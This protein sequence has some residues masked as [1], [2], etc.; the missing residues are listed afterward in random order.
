M[1]GFFSLF[2]S[3][4]ACDVDVFKSLRLSRS[5]R[6]KKTCVERLRWR[7]CR[8]ASAPLAVLDVSLFVTPLYASADGLPRDPY[9]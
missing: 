9:S 5:P 7:T 8:S 6:E 4:R 3:G 1:C 2:I